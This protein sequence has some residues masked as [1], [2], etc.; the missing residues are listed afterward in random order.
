MTVIYKQLLIQHEGTGD[1]V[2]GSHYSQK[3]LNEARCALCWSKLQY[4][5]KSLMLKA[6]RSDTVHVTDRQIKSHSISAIS[7][8]MSWKGLLRDRVFKAVILKQLYCLCC[9]SMALLDAS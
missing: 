9:C 7:H 5:E 8:A 6:S 3:Q 1:V 4:K 2:S